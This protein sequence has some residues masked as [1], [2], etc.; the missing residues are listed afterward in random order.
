MLPQHFVNLNSQLKVDRLHPRGYLPK[1]PD[2]RHTD[3]IK[4]KGQTIKP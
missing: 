4:V 1:P 3:K 2:Y